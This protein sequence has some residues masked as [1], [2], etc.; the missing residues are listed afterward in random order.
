MEDF[1]EVNKALKVKKKCDCIIML[2]YL[3]GLD[4]EE[5]LPPVAASR[6]GHAW[7]KDDE[8]TH[9][10]QC[11]KEFSISRRKVSNPYYSSKFLMHIS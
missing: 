4:S 8:A 11:Q 3:N 9:C 10:K 2:G 5:S 6:Q 7:L 1:K